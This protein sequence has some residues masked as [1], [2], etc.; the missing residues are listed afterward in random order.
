ML[1]GG[2]DVVI[3]SPLGGTSFGSFKVVS[4]KELVSTAS[5]CR[6]ASFAYNASLG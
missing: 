4:A 3:T 2:A 1:S 6:D 5:S